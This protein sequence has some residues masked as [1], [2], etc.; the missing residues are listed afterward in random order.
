VRLLLAQLAQSCAIVDVDIFA[1]QSRTPEFQAKNPA[2]RVPVLELPSGA[3]LPESNAIAWYLAD[4]TPLLPADRWSRA[5]VVRWMSFEQYEIEPVIGTARFWQLTGR[6][7]ERERELAAKLEWGGRTLAQLERQ[8]Q[9]RQFI[10]GDVYSVADV[11]L[12][13]YTHLAPEAG[14]SLTSFPSLRH[15]IARVEAT[16][17]FVPGPAPYPANAM[18]GPPSTP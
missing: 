16:P 1:G 14:L 9:A 10:L 11:V 8:L 6:S 17:R 13:A 3:T 5:Q 15:W 12:Y 2:G 18:V 7:R 4:G